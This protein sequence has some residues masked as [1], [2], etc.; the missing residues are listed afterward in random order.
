LLSVNST[1][2]IKFVSEVEKPSVAVLNAWVQSVDMVPI[3]H[4]R[5]RHHFVLL[6][7]IGIQKDTYWVNDPG[8]PQDT[9]AYGDIA[10]VILYRFTK[11]QK[12]RM[13]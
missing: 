8:Y 11:K 5:N 1:Y 2:D 12:K 4:V 9:Y 7:G 3:A 10:D 13:V 6:I